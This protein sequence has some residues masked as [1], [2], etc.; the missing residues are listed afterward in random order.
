MQLF[1]EYLYV[2]V[3]DVMIT[4]YTIFFNDIRCP[5]ASTLT[6]INIYYIYIHQIINFCMILC[7]FYCGVC[8][9]VYTPM[10]GLVPEI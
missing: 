2:H 10:I 8:S 7:T 1:G 9:S 4:Q 3:N 6:Y 5:Q